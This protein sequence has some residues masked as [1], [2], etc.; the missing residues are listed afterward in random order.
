M[1]SGLCVLGVGSTAGRWKVMRATMNTF[2]PLFFAAP[3][4][5]SVTSCAALDR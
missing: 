5:A 4:M 3:N 2:K 1:S